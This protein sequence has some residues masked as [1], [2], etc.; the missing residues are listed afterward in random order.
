VVV[1]VVVV[2]GGIVVVVVVVGM[3]VVVVVVAAVALTVI[4]CCVLNALPRGSVTVSVT[5]K[6]PSAD[7]VTTGDEAWEVDGEPCVNVQPKMA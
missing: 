2:V 4:C 1:V 3:V 5:V 7:H 6:V